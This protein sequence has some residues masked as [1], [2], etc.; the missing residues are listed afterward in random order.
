MQGLG[1]SGQVKGRHT[2]PLETQPPVQGTHLFLIEAGHLLTV[3]WSVFP[4]DTSCFRYA[5]YGSQHTV[6]PLLS[7]PQEEALP[8]QRL[9]YV[10]GQGLDCK[11][12]DQPSLGDLLTKTLLFWG[13]SFVFLQP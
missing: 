3:R 7:R 1:G 8:P 12:L 2:P 4:H 9:L 13:I 5:G 11:Q 6:G 10:V